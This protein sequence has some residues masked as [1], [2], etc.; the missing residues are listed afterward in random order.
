MGS[1]NDMRTSTPRFRQCP[2]CS[3]ENVGIISLRL[4]EVK[5]NPSVGT[6]VTSKQVRFCEP[7]SIAVY[8]ELLAILTDPRPTT[9]K[10][11]P[12]ERARV[13]DHPTAK[14]TRSGSTKERDDEGDSAGRKGVPR[15]AGADREAIGGSARRHSA[16]HHLRLRGLAELDGL[17]LP[18]LRL[19]GT[20]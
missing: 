19:Y 4:A 1:F 15:M 2:R 16:P 17:P 9:T 11:R 5:G 14:T 8:E 10:A 12:H 18:L 3:D 6:L 7:C 13:T 20:G